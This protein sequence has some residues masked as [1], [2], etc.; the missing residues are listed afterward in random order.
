[1]RS[2]F[3]TEAYSSVNYFAH[4][5]RYTDRPYF[6][7]G[8]ATPDWLSMADRRVRLRPQHVQPFADGSGQPQ[9]EFA[10]GVLQHMEDDDRFH[11]SAAFFEVSGA[12]LPLFR[13]LLEPHDGFRPGFLAHIVTELL[14]DA[15]L[16]E[17]HPE[18]LRAYYAAIDAVDADS[19]QR[20]VNA[21]AKKP[22]E[23]LAAVL[24]LFTRE[25][26]LWDYLDSE[27][28]LYRLNQV[29]RRVKLQPLPPETTTVL[30]ESRLLVRARIDDLILIP[31]KP[32]TKDAPP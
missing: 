27:R 22:T 32:P 3:P 20:C 9:A 15:V 10:A 23:R 4:G 12:L 8:T 31:V 1:M 21:M 30:D 2:Y 25:G 13:K 11:R 14:M 7:A 18:M 28:L 24:P 19:I 29:M 26:F 6:L 5:I 16:I 17:R